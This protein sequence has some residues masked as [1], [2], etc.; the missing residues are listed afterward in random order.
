MPSRMTMI[1]KVSLLKRSEPNSQ[2]GLLS[3]MMWVMVWGSTRSNLSPPGVV[4]QVDFRL[5]QWDELALLGLPGFDQLGSDFGVHHVARSQISDAEEHAQLLVTLTYDAV[6]AEDQRL[7]SLLW[8]GDLNKHA[9]HHQSIGK[10]SPGW[11]GPSGASY[12]R[13]SLRS[14]SWSRTQ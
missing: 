3:L 10:W 13:G 6:L 5:L 8:A 9:A 7:G 14:P 12:P 1:S 11:T 4:A 2:N